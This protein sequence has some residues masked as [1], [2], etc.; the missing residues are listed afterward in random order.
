MMPVHASLAIAPVKV[1]PIPV[2]D[3]DDGVMPAAADGDV[4]FRVSGLCHIEQGEDVHDFTFNPT[5]SM[6]FLT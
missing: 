4:G 1:L 5:F 3:N 6:Y 2:P